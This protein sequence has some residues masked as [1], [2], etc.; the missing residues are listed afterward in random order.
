MLESLKSS[1]R[2]YAWINTLKDKILDVPYFSECS[3]L[4]MEKAVEDRVP[5]EHLGKYFCQF[6]LS[7]PYSDLITDVRTVSV[8]S[9]QKLEKHHI[10]PLG[11]VTKIGEST[12]HLRTDKTNVF[13]SPLNYVYITDLANNEISDKS[14]SDYENSITATA[15]AVLNIVNYPSVNDLS[16]EIK[17]KAWLSERHKLIKGQIQNRV[18]SLL[19]T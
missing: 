8:F 9:K 6:Y 15:K 18:T 2:G 14:L 5:K 3:F 4:L 10:I 16:D 13:N 17:V 7:R 1:R 19:S 12:D 11:S